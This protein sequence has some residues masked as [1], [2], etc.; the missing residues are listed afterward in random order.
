MPEQKGPPEKELERVEN[1][2]EINYETVK[3]F[4]IWAP[5]DKIVSQEGNKSSNKSST[6][7]AIM[8][9]QRFIEEDILERKEGP[10]EWWNE[11]NY[12]SKFKFISKKKIMCC[13]YISP[14]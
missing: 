3:K 7:K 5:L 13:S 9:I 12:I 1:K 8:D 4:S 11:H 6:A 2:E 14:M 10:L